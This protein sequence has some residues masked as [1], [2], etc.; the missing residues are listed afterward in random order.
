MFGDTVYKNFPFYENTTPITKNPL[1]CLIKRNWEP[2][3]TLIGQTGFP[4]AEIAGN[5]L[6]SE[7]EVRVTVRLPP[8][9]NGEK[10]EQTLR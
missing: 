7:I 4:E 1:Q 10:A 6:H 8:T 2:T 5:V 9:F 3:V